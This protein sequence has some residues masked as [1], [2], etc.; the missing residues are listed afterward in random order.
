MPSGGSLKRTVLPA[1]YTARHPRPDDLGAMFALIRKIEIADE[2]ECDL[3]EEDLQILQRTTDPDNVWFVE[4]G[5]GGLVAYAAI[6]P[7]HPTRLRTWAGV[8]PAHR[9]KG[10]GTHL[11]HLVDERARELTAKAPEGEPVM[12]G[13][14]AGQLNTDAAP[15]LERHGYRLARKFWKMGI[16]LNE[17]P[18]E[19]VL[20]EGFTIETMRPGT[21]RELFDASE[22]AFQDH[23]DH[24]PHDYDEWRAWTVERE[25]F[26]PSVWLVVYDGDE[27]AAGAMNYL[28]PRESWVGVLFVRRPWRRR[29]LGLA[30][31]NASFREFR[32]RGVPKAA[33]GVDTENLTGAT[34]LYERAG[35][36]VVRESSVYWKEVTRA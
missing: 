32:K 27:I 31:L 24:V 19:P 33:L 13:Q 10:I 34:Q 29:G 6:R 20:P 15:L 2:G 22:E 17:E 3:N 26:D 4:D 23:W 14:D 11:L 28:E 7:R 36:H 12:L 35:M 25:S 9:G 16:D 8:V 1:G 21:E 5:D 30:L 18:P